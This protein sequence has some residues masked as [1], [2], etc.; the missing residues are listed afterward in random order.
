ML[1][2]II[3]ELR[4]V[5]VAVDTRLD[6][7]ESDARV[8]LMSSTGTSHGRSDIHQRVDADIVNCEQDRMTEFRMPTWKATRLSTS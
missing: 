1:Q 8:Y 2:L 6:A 4:D 5:C 3:M 7:C